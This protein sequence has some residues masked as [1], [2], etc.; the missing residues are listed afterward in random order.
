MHLGWREGSLQRGGDTLEEETPLKRRHAQG[1]Q[2]AGKIPGSSSKRRHQ[3]RPCLW[4][5]SLFQGAPF[6]RGTHRRTL[7]GASVG[8][9]QGV[10]E[11]VGRLPGREPPSHDH[12]QGLRTSA[13]LAPPCSR[14]LIALRGGTAERGGC[15][16]DGGEGRCVKGGRG[17]GDS[18]TAFG[19]SL[20]HQRV[21][22]SAGTLRMSQERKGQGKG[23]RC[24]MAV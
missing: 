18:G 6:F 24:P 19:E 3:N 11:V 5:R 9:A 7:A 23:G 2:L 15:G 13:T 16:R 21:R 1:G 12:P 17:Q 14:A 20:A 22:V 10:G 4:G 8:L